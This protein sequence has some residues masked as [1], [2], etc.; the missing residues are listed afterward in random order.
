M[1]DDETLLNGGGYVTLCPSLQ[2][3]LERLLHKGYAMNALWFLEDF[4][5][6]SEDE[7]LKRL[8]ALVAQKEV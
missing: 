7:F 5:G 3:E 4:A 1:T 6:L 8:G 2:R